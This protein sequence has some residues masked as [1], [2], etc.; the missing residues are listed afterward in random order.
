[1]VIKIRTNDKSLGQFGLIRQNMVWIKSE[2]S[3]FTSV[4][5]LFS[6]LMPRVAQDNIM[7]IDIIKHI[8]GH[9]HE[10]DLLLFRDSQRHLFASEFAG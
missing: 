9:F 2:C 8:T 10:Q 6:L 1:M 4:Y 3:S 7:T 5:S